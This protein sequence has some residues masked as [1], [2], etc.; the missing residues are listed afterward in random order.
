V[1]FAVIAHYHRMARRCDRV[2]TDMRTPYIDDV[3][4]ALGRECGRVAT[5]VVGA[6]DATV[7]VANCPEWSVHQL[8][9]HLVTVARRYSDGPKA[10]ERGLMILG[11]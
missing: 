2:G 6:P 7:R 9:A 1:R 10:G 8:A 11:R 4:T 3:T 5:L